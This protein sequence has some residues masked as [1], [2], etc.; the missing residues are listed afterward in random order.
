MRSI[1]Q[2]ATV[3]IVTAVSSYS[4]AQPDVV[5]ATSIA[6]LK[7]CCTTYSNANVDDFATVGDGGGGQFVI[8]PLCSSGDDGVIVKETA[9][10]Q[11]CWYRQFTGA[12]HLKWYGVTSTA[13]SGA[14]DVTTQLNAA[15]TIAAGVTSVPNT[16]ATAAAN[17]VVDTDGM[18]IHVSGNGNTSGHAIDI[19]NNVRLT[20][21]ATPGGNYKVSSYPNYT[22]TPATIV[23]IENEADS[24]APIA[25]GYNS[26]FDHCIVLTTG[27]NTEG[28]N[29]YP[30]NLNPTTTAQA[31]QD[32]RNMVANA[33]TAVDCYNVPSC[34]VHDNLIIGF[35]TAIEV[36][37]SSHAKIDNNA[38]DA[39][40]GVFLTNLGSPAVINGFDMDSFLTGELNQTSDNATLTVTEASDGAC[41][42]GGFTPA[43]LANF[44]TGDPVDVTG[45]VDRTTG[46]DLANCN[47]LWSV[48]TV[49]LIH[50]TIELAGSLFSPPT[51]TAS[52]KAGSQVISVTSAAG[53]WPGETVSCSDCGSGA[54]VVDVS[55]YTPLSAVM[56]GMSMS[57]TCPYEVVISNV[58][59][60]T[61]TNGTVTFGYPTGSPSTTV[62]LYPDLRPWAG[63]SA[64]GAGTYTPAYK[65]TGVTGSGTC[66]QAGT[67]TDGMNGG[68]GVK[69]VNASCFGHEVAYAWPGAG[70]GGCIDCSSDSHAEIEDLG[71]IALL[72]RG[73][74]TG[75]LGFSGMAQ[76][77][78]GG[79]VIDLTAD[80]CVGL[81]NSQFNPNTEGAI[82]FLAVDGCFTLGGV[83]A[84]SNGSADWLLETGATGTPPVAA[85]N[86]TITGSNSP[87][88][89]IYY[90]DPT[91][92]A[93]SSCANN[94][95]STQTCA[96]S[97]PTNLVS[98]GT[99]PTCAS[100][101]STTAPTGTNNAMTVVSDGSGTTEV[102]K[103]ANQ[104]FTN[105]PTCVMSPDSYGGYIFS[106]TQTKLTI[107]FS[108]SVVSTDYVICI[109]H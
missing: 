56:C 96:N 40:V 13:D 9:G 54:T 75:Y 80:H 50:Q 83:R 74:M 100:G 107:K 39:D 17:G 2:A 3:I 90:E 63:A 68:I 14:P 70:P 85:V 20:C 66:I 72:V 41:Q 91:L 65:P 18:R 47:G 95:F 37:M 45:A 94:L 24:V 57:S 102:V 92:A 62:Y 23:L 88:T 84:N 21:D 93:A 1:M 12:V 6:D 33:S 53:I 99:A 30:I 34:N 89:T 44:A 76:S 49:D 52:W 87:N 10:A 27:T 26:E 105:P 103:F 32:V 98:I 78:S 31:M 81:N 25:L 7:S 67:D 97:L 48:G 5:E 29:D 59:A 82:A 36:N 15:L 104:G 11:R 8:G 86:G 16:S 77:A 71:Q 60:N 73:A 55:T 101:C 64:G 28:S 51:Y 69:V 4:N 109:G 106:V 58:L 46:V 42:V 43:D 35:D 22:A 19:P 79:A 108:S 38:V 61:N